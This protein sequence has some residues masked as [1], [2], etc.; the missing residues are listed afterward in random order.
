MLQERRAAEAL[1]DALQSSYDDVSDGAAIALAVLADERAFDALCRR[2]KASRNSQVLQALV[3]YRA[4]LIKALDTGNQETQ[5]QAAQ[6]LGDI[7]CRD[8]SV[9]QA[10]IAATS[11]TYYGV[12]LTAIRSLGLLGA[13]TS[14]DCVRKILLDAA[15]G[16]DLR[17]EAAAVLEKLNWRPVNANEKIAFAIAKDRLDE[18]LEVGPIALEAVVSHLGTVKNWGQVPGQVKAIVER[19]T[20]AEFVIPLLNLLKRDD[21]A[22]HFGGII[23]GALAKIR[24]KGVEALVQLIPDHTQAYY[25]RL[26]AIEALGEIKEQSAIAA[27]ITVV[28]QGNYNLKGVAIDALR[29]IGDIRAIQSLTTTAMRAD[30]SLARRTNEALVRILEQSVADASPEQLYSIA[31]LKP[32]TVIWAGTETESIEDFAESLKLARG[33]L[34][35]RGFNV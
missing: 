32:V 35:R 15:R 29:E 21:L 4:P 33:E 19:F 25:P 26:Q 17:E 22:Q 2:A 31:A 1:H 12:R 20:S 24:P 30:Y 34:I 27:L 8:E 11:A 28:D 16:N 14:I 6:L 7:G 10:L 13:G 18:A 9:V 5:V 23:S 3:N